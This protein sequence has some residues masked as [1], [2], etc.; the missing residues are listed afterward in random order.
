MGICEA[1]VGVIGLEHILDGCGD[2]RAF[3]GI[4]LML[5]IGVLCPERGSG[6]S[7]LLGF[8]FLARVLRSTSINKSKLH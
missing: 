4:G 6:Y 1:Y 3:G 5:Y 8:L 7:L 2:S